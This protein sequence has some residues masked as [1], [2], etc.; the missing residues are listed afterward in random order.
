M[1][2]APEAPERAGEALSILVRR[3]KKKDWISR[4]HAPNARERPPERDA[5]VIPDNRRMRE[6]HHGRPASRPSHPSFAFRLIAAS[7]SLAWEGVD[8]AWRHERKKPKMRQRQ[9]LLRQR[10][11]QAT[12]RTASSP[13]DWRKLQAKGARLEK[14]VSSLLS[15]APGGLA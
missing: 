6:R 8:P 4:I 1:P 9:F 2:R 15:Q 14:A 13:F 12:G 10:A 3:E 7:A 5:R 11:G